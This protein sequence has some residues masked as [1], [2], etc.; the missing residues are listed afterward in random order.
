MTLRLFETALGLHLRDLP[1]HLVK[2][3][4]KMCRSETL[5]A[6]DET[7]QRHLEDLE[8]A[9]LANADIVVQF[10]HVV[11]LC[12]SITKTIHTRHS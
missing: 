10:L 2:H 4:D 11:G 5:Q 12:Y 8:T 7:V 6:K 9:K 3:E 1:S